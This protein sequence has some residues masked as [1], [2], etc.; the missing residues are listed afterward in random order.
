MAEGSVAGT[1]QD[2]EDG[3]LYDDDVDLD[4]DND[5][6]MPMNDAADLD[7]DFLQSNQ[8]TA[9]ARSIPSTPKTR[10]PKRRK[11][12]MA[13]SLDVISESIYEIREGIKQS[14]T[15]RFDK[16]DT[17]KEVVDLFFSLKAI[18]RISQQTMT[19]A[20]DNFMQEPTRAIWFLEM[21]DAARE[22][23]IRYKFG[24]L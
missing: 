11:A 24:G 20:S 21:D 18:P 17:K 23:Y 14:H 13:A 16:E 8:S 2:V 12:S 4:D 15:I 19:I 10:R 5:L 7:E 1:P 6:N 3:N 9:S 22:D